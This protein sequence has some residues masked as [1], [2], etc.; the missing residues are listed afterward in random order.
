MILV[1]GATGNLGGGIARTLLSQGKSVRVLARP[2]SSYQSLV[3][4]GAQAVL[5][6]LKDRTSL[7]AACAGV[8]TVITTA[9]SAQRGGEDNVQTVDR[10]G[11]RNLIDAAKAGGV[12]H[13]IFVSALGA[14]PANPIPFMQ[15]KGETEEYLKA[16]GL[17]YTILEPNIFMEIWTGIVVGM[18]VA[19]GQA[20]TLVGEGLRKHSFVSVRDVLAYAIAAV[21]NPA[22]QNQTIVIGGPQALSWRDV[23]ATYE[24]VL[25][26]SIAV[27][28]AAPG[29]PLPLPGEA[30][31]LMW[32]FET[33]DSPVDMSE[34]SKTY[35]IRP[36]LL[37][38][39]VASGLSSPA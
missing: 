25:G 3:E 37:E 30:A 11:N 29:E 15:A 35:G 7:K 8:D 6:D 24:R 10:E 16:S 33:F 22:A 39:V 5:G 20:V 36:T 12:S 17:N 18:P 2:N 4:A 38:E 21:D 23:I 28:W 13:F 32:G 9:N 34:T 27:K 31:N 26:R 1:V 14:S 19:N